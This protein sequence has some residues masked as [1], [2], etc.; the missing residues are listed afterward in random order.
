METPLKQ[1]LVKARCSVHGNHL[2]VVF[3]RAANG[4]WEAQD[5]FKISSGQ[6]ERGYQGGLLTN[7][8][9]AATYR[10]CPY[11][12]NKSVF[13]C[14][15]CKTLN[16]QGA[17]KSVGERVQVYCAGCKA[18]GFIEGQVEQIEGFGDL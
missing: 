6:A 12:S 13:L 16:C 3:T 7:V 9:I 11:C 18:S 5:T 1:M 10:G 14:N 2:A 17:A 4:F 15:G 8:R